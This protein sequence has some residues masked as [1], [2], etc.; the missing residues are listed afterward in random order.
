MVPAPPRIRAVLRPAC[1]TVSV[2]ALRTPT[3][4]TSFF[5]LPTLKALLGTGFGLTMTPPSPPET[6]PPSPVGVPP[7]WPGSVGPG[8]GGPGSVGPG[9]VG[10]GSV[11]PGS[12][13]TAGSAGSPPPNVWI[14]LL[15]VSA[16]STRPRGPV[17]RPD[18]KAISPPS[19]PFLPPWQ[20]AAAVQT[21]RPVPAWDES[22]SL[23]HVRSNE[24]SRK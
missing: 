11:G 18:G 23:P 1:F 5:S 8:V 13:G 4:R 6:V 19:V 22:T 14:R 3:D 16:T 15:P 21:S 17:A 12:A 7:P 20:L 24:P 2:P 9:S 10:P